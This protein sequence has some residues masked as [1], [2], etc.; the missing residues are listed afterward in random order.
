VKGQADAQVLPQFLVTGM[1]AVIFSIMEPDG[2]RAIPGTHP[3]A[4]PP[5]G[6]ATAGVDLGLGAEMGDVAGR[7]TQRAEGLVKAGSPD[8]VGL[9]FRRVGK[10][11]SSLEVFQLTRQDRWD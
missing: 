5:V 6:N 1:S 10:A 9:I 4:G 11:H 8:A 7:L 2:S 3:N